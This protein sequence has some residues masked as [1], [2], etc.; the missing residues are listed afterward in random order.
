MVLDM[1][2]K[3]RIGREE[4]QSRREGQR[5]FIHILQAY[6]LSPLF[7]TFI[8]LLRH[9]HLTA[10]NLSRSFFSVKHFILLQLMTYGYHKLT[11]DLSLIVKNKQCSCIKNKMQGQYFQE[12]DSHIKRKP[13]SYPCLVLFLPS[14][15]LC[16]NGNSMR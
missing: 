4:R 5:E 12:S 8:L 2:Q 1:L 13:L 14:A 11:L 6:L 7:L 9:T 15:V 10:H 16:N 3:V